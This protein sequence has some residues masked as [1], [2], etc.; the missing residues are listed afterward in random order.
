M[1]HCHGYH[2]AVQASEHRVPRRKAARGPRSPRS[3]RSP[4]ARDGLGGKVV[5]PSDV[6]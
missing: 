3:P 4:C 5:R 1:K 2:D 6:R